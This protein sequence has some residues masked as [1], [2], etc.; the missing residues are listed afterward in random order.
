MHWQEAFEYL[1]SGRPL[2]PRQLEAFAFN[3]GV[4]MQ[5]WLPT[6][7]H[8]LVDDPFLRDV[9]LRYPRGA[10]PAPLPLVLR[11]VERMLRADSAAA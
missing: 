11:Q 4:P 8:M 2:A 9:T 10:T 7:A 6:D 1:R 5:R 3:Y